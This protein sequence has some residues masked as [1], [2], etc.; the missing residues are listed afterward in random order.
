MKDNWNKKNV[1]WLLLYVVLYF[2]ATLLVCSMGAIH[3]ILFVCYQI[4]AGILVTG[5]AARGFARIRSFGTAL[6][7]SAGLCL[8]FAAAG[9]FNAWHCIPIVIIGILAEL[10]GLV[11]GNEKWS[12]IVVKSVIMSFSTFGYYGQIWFNRDFTYD[13]AIEEMPEGYAQ[14]LMDASPAWTLPVVIV[15]GIVLAVVSAN[16][17]ARIFKLEK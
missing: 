12:A 4:T 14:A 10:A 6:I 7:Y 11:M 17:T 1:L 15:V 8:I 3:P 2:A 16:L 5:V 13:C 9:E